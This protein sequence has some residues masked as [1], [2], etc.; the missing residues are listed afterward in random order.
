MTRV[1]AADNIDVPG[2]SES[3]VTSKREFLNVPLLLLIF[4]GLLAICMVAC[5]EKG[6]LDP[7]PPPCPPDNPPDLRLA[8]LDAVGGRLDYCDPD[9][10]PVGIGDPLQD[11]LNRFPSIQADTLVFCAILE[12][13]NLTRGQEYR[14]EQ[15]IAINELYKQISAIILL[16]VG[17]GYEFS[18]LVPKATAT[19]GNERVIGTVSAAGSVTIDR[20]EAG[21]SLNCP[22]CLVSGVRI[23]TPSGEVAIQDVRVG[24]KVWTT[25]AQGHRVVGVVNRIG[26]MLTA[27]GHEVIRLTLADGRVVRASPG[28]PTADRRVIGELAVGD[29]CDGS[30]VVSTE[31]VPYGNDR[32][33]DL[34]PSGP[35]GTYFANG[36]LLGSTLA[37]P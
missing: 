29:T 22:I 12:H 32:T 35:T 24:M 1:S 33:H 3:V 2:R 20:R 9:V 21:E 10:Y 23:A 13:E 6:P 17:D 4:L 18:L 34:L 27:P 15:Y 14:P 25:N 5:N 31:R 37:I 8:V 16:P 11:A 19:T 7:N 28:H 30:P 36:I 26:S